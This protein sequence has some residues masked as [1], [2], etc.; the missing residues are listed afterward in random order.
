MLKDI[1]QVQGAPIAQ[2]KLTHFVGL[3]TFTRDQFAAFFTNENPAPTKVAAQLTRF[4][5]TYVALDEAYRIDDY[6]LDTER[7]KKADEDCDHTIMGVKKMVAA[8]Q[9]FDFNP[10]VKASADRMMQA[11][12]KFDI[13]TAEDYLGENNKLQQFLQ[14]VN[15]S[16]QLTADAETLGLTA[17]LA[18]LQEK[19]AL[20]R[21]LLTQRG[22]AQAPKGTMKT[23]RLAM[24][25]EYRWLIAIL[26]A[27]ALM[28]DN[29]HQF[30]TLIQTL[31]QNIDY[32]K[33]VVLPR[34]GGGSGSSSSQNNSGNS[35]NSGNSDSG[36]GSGDNQGG[37]DNNGGG[38][39]TPQPD[40]DAGFG[41]G[42]NQGGGDNNGGGGT[43]PQPD[44]DAGF[45][46]GD[47]Q[48]G[49]DN[50]GGGTTPQPDPDAGFGGN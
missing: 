21:D 37:G 28:S 17:A 9:T 42:D 35:G 18:Q 46:G 6:S 16:A 20:V 40:P 44:P 38:G 1:L 36:N 25:P 29:E 39:T 31:N 26:N 10:T 34:Q 48:G 5:Q 50:N 14:E 22:L 43:T 2:M 3:M 15:T 19:V 33:T 13:N 7:L 45:G 23:A 49:G 32:L 4:N 11:I 47:N 41:G 27:A 8:Q 24:E 30:D 12:D